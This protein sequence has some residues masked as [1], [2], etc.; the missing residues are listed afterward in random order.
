MKRKHK[1]PPGKSS[2]LITFANANDAMA[3]AMAECGLSLKT[4]QRRVDGLSQCQISYRNH[5]LAKG[6]Y[7]YPKGVGLATAWRNG[8]SEMWVQYGS[9]LIAI[10]QKRIM[11][12]AAPQFAHPTPKTV[13]K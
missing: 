6:Y 2:S 1:Q 12:E 13:E 11:E 7:H 4:I 10:A 8:R 9:E 3:C 5:K